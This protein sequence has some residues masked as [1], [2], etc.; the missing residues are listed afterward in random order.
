LPGSCGWDIVPGVRGRLQIELRAARPSA[1]GTGFLA[2]GSVLY[3]GWLIRGV[4]ELTSAG[5]LTEDLQRGLAVPAIFGVILLGYTILRLVPRPREQVIEFT[6][7]GVRFP[8]RRSR[9]TD[10][11]PYDEI[12]SIQVSGRPPRRV[13]IIGGGDHAYVFHE[14]EFVQ[15]DAMNRFV[16]ELRVRIRGLPKGDAQLTEIDEKVRYTQAILHRQPRVTES[17]LIL[18]GIAF[19]IQIAVGAIDDPF[20]LVGL[21]AN[22]R[23]LVDDGQYFRLITANF[24]HGNFVHL[25]LNSMALHQVGGL[26]ERL[27][28]SPRFLVLYLIGGVAGAATSAWFDVGVVSL[29]ASTSIFAVLGA[30]FVINFKYRGRLPAGIRQ[31]V[32]WWLFILG[33]SAALPLILPQIDAGAH[34]GGF[35]LGIGLMLVLARRRKLTELMVGRS[36]RG[37]MITAITCA[38]VAV[39]NIGLGVVRG[40][41]GAAEDEARVL[42][43]YIERDDAT[44]PELNDLAWRMVINP[45]APH[46]RLDA[47]LRSA[48]RAL[49]LAPGD[50]AITDTVATAHFRVGNLDRAIEL[51]RTVLRRRDT[52]EFPTQLARFERA[53]FVRDG[54][55]RV[56]G[57]S[58][59]AV[60]AVLSPRKDG[61]RTL[62]LELDGPQPTDGATIHLTATERGDL[63]GFAE[64]TL[65]RNPSRTVEHRDGEGRYIL[66]PGDAVIEAAL[67]DTTR[68]ELAAGTSSFDLWGMEKAILELPGPFA[69]SVSEVGPDDDAG[70]PAN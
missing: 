29:G 20:K 27:I 46:E 28:G 60:S 47:A 55:L 58:T 65:G 36:S 69:E 12:N 10:E 3:W 7:A 23:V 52:L 1:L 45:D 43:A 63:V 61:V 66:W 24:L 39:F 34:I 4:L 2:A 11:I 54:V 48:E 59:I 6:D 9:R 22:S 16:M 31:S 57:T 50:D 13:A 42:A 40:L 51:E 5:Q 53:R 64:V 35:V 30:F 17:L 32:P 67:I 26:V 25:F 70:R 21:G 33:L 14:L 37:L 41:S 38:L 62:T 68:T 15:P 18:I 44:A 49:E 19:A 8:V 56:G